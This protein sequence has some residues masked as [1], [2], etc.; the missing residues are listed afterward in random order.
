MVSPWY[1]SLNCTIQRFKAITDNGTEFHNYVLSIAA[2]PLARALSERANGS[3][4]KLSGS[5]SMH[6][7]SVAVQS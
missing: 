6:L 7:V 3:A 5:A 1:D 2:T 4:S